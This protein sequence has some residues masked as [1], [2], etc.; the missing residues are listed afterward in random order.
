MTF[1]ACTAEAVSV[2]WREV[3]P[4]VEKALDADFTPEHVRNMLEAGR[5][6]LWYTSVDDVI[7]CV[8]VTSIHDYPARSVCQIWLTSGSLPDDWELCLGE[9]ERWAARQGCGAIAVHG[10]PGWERKLKGWGKKTVW[11]EKEISTNTVH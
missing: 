2:V 9:L 6:Q 8:C 5:A 11:L 4:F 3:L 1:H 7:Q 10:R